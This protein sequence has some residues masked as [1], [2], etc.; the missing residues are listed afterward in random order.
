MAAAVR[1]AA[2]FSREA[3]EAKWRQAELEAPGP[4]LPADVALLETQS[5][6]LEAPP[7]GVHAASAL[8]GEYVA[9]RQKR[10]GELR[11][12]E[13]A[14]GP[15]YW[16]AY[17]LRRG[18]FTRG[19]VFESG[20]VARLKADAA[21]PRAQRQWLGDFHQPRV[22]VHVGVTKAGA[23]CVRYVDVLV[24]E[25]LPLAG[26]PPRVETFSFKSRDFKLFDKALLKVQVTEDASA[27]LRYYGGTL[28]IRR[29]AL[30]LRDVEVRVQRVRL[31]Y[32]GG[33]LLPE[34]PEILRPAVEKIETSVQGVE[35]SFQ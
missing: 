10:L 11:A 29:P 4:R 24:I 18:Q 1:E 26:Q 22:E 9:Y 32:E 34:I 28:N 25:Q 33:R 5:P 2:G 30:R 16:E 6:R 7:P 31:I 23:Q 15:L 12:G 21:L 14:R 35:V 20:M 19:L 27:A 17:E 8:W 13:K 3:L